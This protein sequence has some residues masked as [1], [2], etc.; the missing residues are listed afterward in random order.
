MCTRLRTTM[1]WDVNN[2]LSEWWLFLK[3]KWLFETT[4][5]CLSKM[6]HPLAKVNG[7]ETLGKKRIWRWEKPWSSHLSRVFA[8][9]LGWQ[10]GSYLRPSI[11]S[12]RGGA[13][14]IILSDNKCSRT[15]KELKISTSSLISIVNYLTVSNDNP[16]KYWRCDSTSIFQSNLL[17]FK[18]LIK[19]FYHE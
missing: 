2:L 14:T 11:T 12:S 18:V 7:T 6:S 5:Y 17:F 19:F 10:I 3:P 4:K 15:T 16:S 8:I 9:L 1:L 13:C